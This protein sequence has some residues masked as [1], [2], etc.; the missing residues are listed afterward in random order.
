MGQAT[1]RNILRVRCALCAVWRVAN[2]KKRKDCF[3]DAVPLLP[4]L[5]ANGGVLLSRVPELTGIPQSTVYHWASAGR[6]TVYKAGVSA[7]VKLD[8]V[9]RV[10]NRPLGEPLPEPSRDFTYDARALMALRVRWSSAAAAFWQC[11]AEEQAAAH[12]VCAF[13]AGVV[14]CAR[15]CAVEKKSVARAPAQ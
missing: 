13:F 12:A 9:L 15:E 10:R 8:D 7:F 6:F 3:A 1:T 5:E 4:G 11:G 2:H 14:L